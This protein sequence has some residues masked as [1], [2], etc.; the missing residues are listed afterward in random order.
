MHKGFNDALR[1]RDDQLRQRDE[2]IVQH[3]LEMQQLQAKTAILR[4]LATEWDSGATVGIEH[5][6]WLLS[7]VRSSNNVTQVNA[8][9]EAKQA[10]EMG[11]KEAEARVI[12]VEQE[13]AR[14]KV[15]MGQQLEML[16]EEVLRVLTSCTYPRAAAYTVHVLCGLQV[17]R[18]MAEKDSELLQCQQQ[19]QMA[20]GA[21]P[22]RAA[23]ANPAGAADKAQ[24]AFAQL[25][26]ENERLRLQLG[27]AAAL[28]TPS[29]SPPDSIAGSPQSELSG[30]V[31]SITAISVNSSS[32]TWKR[33]QQSLTPWQRVHVQAELHKRVSAT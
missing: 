10:A 2:Q 11:R 28:N 8:A 18:T 20:R 7:K 17:L 29:S 3:A 1:A 26:D 24:Q 27:Q 32:S 30:S 31:S 9:R 15:L 5:K 16:E 19:L 6:V 13:A 33:L 23:A 4:E 21:A 12:A 14:A 25:Q 22:W